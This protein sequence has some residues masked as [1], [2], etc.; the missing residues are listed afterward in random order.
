MEMCAEWE[1]T[2]WSATVDVPCGSRAGSAREYVG[3]LSCPISQQ[4]YL[5]DDSTKALSKDISCLQPGWEGIQMTER[6]CPDGYVSGSPATA[7]EDTCYGP[8][9]ST[10]PTRPPPYVHSCPL[11]TEHRKPESY[12]GGTLS[13]MGECIGQPNSNETCPAGLQYFEPPNEKGYCRAWLDTCPLGYKGIWTGLE[14]RKGILHCTALPSHTQ[15][16]ATDRFDPYSEL[17]LGMSEQAARIALRGMGFGTNVDEGVDDGP[18]RPGQDPLFCSDDRTTPGHV[19][20]VSMLYDNPLGKMLRLHFYRSRLFYLIGSC[21][22]Y[23][24]KCNELSDR[25]TRQVGAKPRPGCGPTASHFADEVR[26]SW[27]SGTTSICLSDSGGMRQVE[28]L[29]WQL[30]TPGTPRE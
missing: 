8:R 6:G 30:A 15:T 9:P 22:A 18:P 20:C 24:T 13:F 27:H 26:R 4:V 10:R 12:L 2:Y 23:Q 16:V 17:R 7:G 19:E 11:E 3:K 21:Y 1:D 5:W 25:F 29:D 14:Y 28:E